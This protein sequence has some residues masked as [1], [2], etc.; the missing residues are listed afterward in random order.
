MEISKLKDKLVITKDSYNIGEVSEANIDD[1]WMIT[2]LQIKLT[3][4]T[5]KELGFKKPLLGHVT[6]CL[7]IRYVKTIADVITLNSSRIEL[8]EV[9]ECKSD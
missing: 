3:K 7:P 5:T 4:E 9:P 2:H 1:K 8:R 6:I